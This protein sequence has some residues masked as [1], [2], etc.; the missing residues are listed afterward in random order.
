MVRGMSPLELALCLGFVSG[1]R[2]F[3][4]PAAVLIARGT[5]WSIPFVIGAVVEY[6]LDV[7]PSTPSRTGPRGLI[8]RI[9]SGAFSGWLIVTMHGGAG[10]P[11]AIA[12]IVG[13][14]IGAYAG[15]AARIAAIARFGAYPAAFTEDVLA[16]G[17]AVLI[18]TR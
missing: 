3:T 5:L 15:H 4:A 17:L 10:I 11:G 2:M 18:V 6:V 12:G 7:L 16:I 13:A 9:I 14:L 1:L 8:G